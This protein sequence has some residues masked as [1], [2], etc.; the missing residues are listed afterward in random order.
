M[1]MPLQF[2][3]RKHESLK[4]NIREREREREINWQLKY[5]IHATDFSSQ[6]LLQ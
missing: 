3:V 1:N 2:V 6:L 5:K 4:Q